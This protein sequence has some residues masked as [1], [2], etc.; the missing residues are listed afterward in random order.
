[1][2][3]FIDRARIH[4]VVRLMRFI[5]VLGRSERAELSQMEASELP[6]IGFSP[7]KMLQARLFSYGDTQRYRLG[8]NFNNIPVN[9]P[10]CPFHS[11]H[12]D[13]PMRTDNNLGGMLSFHPTSAGLSREQIKQRHVENCS[14]A[15]R[16]Y[17]AGVALA[18]GMEELALV[19]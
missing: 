8:V 7:D 15:D 18:L 10:K 17:G 9:A 1:M 19:R 6:G 14:R 5:D 2:G 11:Y 16:D 4:E 13:R 12:R 3:D